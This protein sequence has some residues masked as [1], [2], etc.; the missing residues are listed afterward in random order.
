MRSLGMKIQEMRVIF[1]YIGIA[2]TSTATF[3]GILVGIMIGV[4]IDYMH[5]ITLPDAY[6]I[7][8]ITFIVPYHTIGISYIL[9]LLTT[10]IISWITTKIINTY[11]AGTIVKF[12]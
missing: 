7:P 2:I 6:Y 1:V 8:Y 4:T 9:I 3:L 5:L 11:E 12:E 10:V